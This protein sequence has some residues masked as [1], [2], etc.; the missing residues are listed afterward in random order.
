MKLTTLFFTCL[1][2]ASCS[3]AQMAFSTKNKKAIELF[4]QAQNEPN[5]TVDPIT[6]GPN[7]SG[8]ISLLNKAL[9]K[10]PLFWEAH[11]MEAEFYELLGNNLAAIDHYR[12]AIK[13]NPKHTPTGSTYFYLGTLEYVVGQYD[14]AIKTLTTYKEYKKASP[15]Y[16]AK[17]DQV[18]NDSKFAIEAMKNPIDYK[19]VNLGPGVNTK[20]PEYFPTITVDGK[21]LLFTRLIDDKRV[22]GEYKKQE[23]FYVSILTEHNTWGTA[24]PMPMNVNTVNNEG[25][26]TFAPDGRSLIFVACADI[27]NS[28]GGKRQGKGSCDLFFTKRIGQDWLDP[29]NLPGEINSGA[30]ESQ[31]SLS[32]DGKTVY[33][34]RQVVSKYGKPDSDIFMSTL[35]ENGK[36]STAVRLPEIINSPE[37]EESVQIHPDGK[38]L[39]FSSRGHQGM[40][41]LDIFVSRLDEKGQWGRP[42]NL[43]YPINTSF[44]ENSLLVSADGEIAF[45]ASDRQG[46]YGDLDIYYFVMPEKYRPIKTLYFDG[47][48]YDA[49]TK[50]PLEGSFSL[51]DLKTGKEVIR[52][53]ADK[54]SGAFTV[55]LPINQE[56]ALSVSYP[57]YTFFSQNFNMTISDNQESF[58]MDVPLVPITDASPIALRNVFFDLNLATLR[59][60]SYI[61]LNKLSDFLKSNPN[62]KIEIGGHTDTRGDAVTNQKLSDAR[63]KSVK[64]YLISQGI[65]SSRLTSVGFGETT[66]IFTD[67][68]ISKMNSENEKE[69]AHQENRRTEYRILK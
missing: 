61:E 4:M 56:Y 58:H 37:M 23:D 25:A 18:I 33:F 52:S 3:T 1:F 2:F 35:G 36:W 13:I 63:A 19:P 29:I 14:N 57:G 9:E 38:T 26:P 66:P 64:D 5:R 69:K 12:E 42:V 54:V 8:A 21:T 44:D 40:G 49:V 7:Y 34:V 11:L 39:Y 55:S 41:G 22:A 60:E 15:Q 27:D 30:W 45:F 51:V 6:R 24:V 62:L 50:K 53:I 16:L 46:G 10:D 68:A 65:S 48:V 32:A 17:A 47:L 43:G 67:E 20:D 31:P 59:P 28:Y